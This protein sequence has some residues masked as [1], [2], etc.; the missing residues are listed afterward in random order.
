MSNVPV[1][2]QQ[3]LEVGSEVLFNVMTDGRGN[4]NVISLAILPAG[5]LQERQTSPS[6]S[7]H[8]SLDLNRTRRKDVLIPLCGLSPQNA[9]FF[10][11]AML[12]CE[13]PD[14]ISSTELKNILNAFVS[15][16]DHHN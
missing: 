11:E 8:S 10:L 13:T 15:Q 7:C 14:H 1:Q 2:H 6:K 3:K 5:S 9:S 4:D 12:H 16:G